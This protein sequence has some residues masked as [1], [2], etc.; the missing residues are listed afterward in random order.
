M[1]GSKHKIIEHMKKQ[2]NIV[3]ANGK[4]KFLENHSKETEVCESQET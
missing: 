4:N 3:Q 1:P 2:G